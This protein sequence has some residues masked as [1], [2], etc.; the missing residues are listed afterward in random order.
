M[1]DT[2]FRYKGELAKY[3]WLLIALF[4]IAFVVFELSGGRLQGKPRSNTAEVLAFAVFGGGFPLYMSVKG[5]YLT[6]KKIICKSRGT[7]CEG[8]IKGETLKGIRDPF[9]ILHISCDGGDVITPPIT[10]GTEQRIA[11]KSCTVY[12]YKELFYVDDIRLCKRGEQG[13]KIKSIA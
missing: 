8:L 7:P 9:V 11:S 3:L 1:R 2:R 6:Y 5:F 13:I 10:L 4:F 12:R